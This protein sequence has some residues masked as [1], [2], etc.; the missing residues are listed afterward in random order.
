MGPPQSEHPAKEIAEI[1]SSDC[2]IVGGTTHTKDEI[3]RLVYAMNIGKPVY[4]NEENDI[5]DWIK[6]DGVVIY[7]REQ[8]PEINRRRV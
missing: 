2:V 4:I 6:F 5:Q 7:K 3:V 8:T 1:F